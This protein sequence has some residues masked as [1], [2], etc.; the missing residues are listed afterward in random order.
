MTRPL[1]HRLRDGRCRDCGQHSPYSAP[2]GC[3]RCALERMAE[4]GYQVVD[5]PA[6]R[7]LHL[8]E[9]RWRLVAA[10][11]SSGRIRS[12]RY[13]LYAGMDD[14]GPLDLPTDGEIGT[15]TFADAHTAHSIALALLERY[16][17]VW[18]VTTV[19]CW[20]AARTEGGS[21]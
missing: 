4:R 18:V 1:P 21:A 12:D 14:G 7:F 17:Q 20:N 13:Y 8:I 11:L 3:C 9:E 5:D 15:W 10:G 6:G 16:E 19:G 2:N